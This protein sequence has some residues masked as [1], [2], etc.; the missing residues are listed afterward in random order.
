MKY[1]FR[2]EDTPMQGSSTTDLSHIGNG[3]AIDTGSKPL[4]TCHSTP[5]CKNASLLS[6]GNLNNDGGHTDKKPRRYT[7]VIIK[8]KKTYMFLRHRPH[9]LQTPCTKNFYCISSIC[10][11]KSSIHRELSV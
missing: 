1:V 8:A 7:L 6:T 3:S 11:E 5:D 4:R 2:C 9:H 10:I